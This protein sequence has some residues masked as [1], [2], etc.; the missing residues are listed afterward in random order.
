MVMHWLVGPRVIHPLVN[1]QEQIWGRLG[2]GPWSGGPGGGG[3]SLSLSPLVV[4]PLGPRRQAS[5][6]ITVRLH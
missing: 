5:D 4:V 6:G 3:G 2:H 1:V